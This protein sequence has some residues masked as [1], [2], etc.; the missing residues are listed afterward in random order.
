MQHKVK[1]QE[2]DPKMRLF[3]ERQKMR[4]SKSPKIYGAARPARE[5]ASSNPCRNTITDDTLIQ[6]ILA[7]HFT[8]ETCRSVNLLSFERVDRRV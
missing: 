8:I 5:H 4:A 3:A 6:Y 1:Y 7:E 2:H